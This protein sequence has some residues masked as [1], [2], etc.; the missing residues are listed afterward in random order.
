MVKLN[1]RIIT[2]L[3]F[4]HILP[5][6]GRWLHF[7]SIVH[8]RRHD[9]QVMSRYVWL[10]LT[11]ANTLFRSA[12]TL[13]FRLWAETSLQ[14]PYWCSRPLI[15]SF[16]GNYAWCH[17]SECR[18]VHFSERAADLHCCQS[19]CLN[20]NKRWSCW[21]IYLTSFVQKM[22]QIEFTMASVKLTHTHTCAYIHTPAALRPVRRPPHCWAIN[23]SWVR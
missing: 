22:S 14:H 6:N 13:I 7:C 17:L 23:T 21:L 3:V 2:V 4:F 20:H 5:C 8:C 19:E 1:H 18:R 12:N 16:G 9:E 15:F 10:Y 11:P